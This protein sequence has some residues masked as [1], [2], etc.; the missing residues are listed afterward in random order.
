M[1]AAGTASSKA[2]G[3]VEVESQQLR[4]TLLPLPYSADATRSRDSS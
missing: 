4:F 2:G 3:G 1:S